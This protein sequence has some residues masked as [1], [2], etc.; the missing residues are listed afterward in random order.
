MFSYNEFIKFIYEFTVTYKFLFNFA[1][2]KIFV[3]WLIFDSL[4]VYILNR[5]NFCCRRAIFI[6]RI[7]AYECFSGN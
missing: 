2:I 5:F 1:M 7:N 6:L 3:I 4:I